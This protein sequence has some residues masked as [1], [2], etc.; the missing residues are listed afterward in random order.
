MVEAIKA[1]NSIK[2]MAE[3]VKTE[4]AENSIK[5]NSRIDKGK[6]IHKTNG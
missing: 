4:K 5:T 3:E 2:Q 6:K 1:N